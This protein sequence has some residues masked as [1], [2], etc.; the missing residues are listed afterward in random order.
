MAKYYVTHK[1]NIENEDY[2][3]LVELI[4][5]RSINWIETLEYVRI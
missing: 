2:M 5:D 1:K 3:N 4:R